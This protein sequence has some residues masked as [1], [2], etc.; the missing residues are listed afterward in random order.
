MEE[1]QHENS[2]LRAVVNGKLVS[3]PETLYDTFILRELST[4]EDE[5]KEGILVG[6]VLGKYQLGIGDGWIALRIE[7]FIKDG[8]L[9]PITKPSPKAP[10]YHRILKKITR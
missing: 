8:L 6:Q 7:Q 10:I 5:F 9:V 4:L 3:V 2:L 1:L